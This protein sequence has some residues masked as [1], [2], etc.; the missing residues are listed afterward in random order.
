MIFMSVTGSS[1]STLGGSGRRNY[2]EQS[3]SVRFEYKVFFTSNLFLS[4]NNLLSNFFEKLSVA[5]S[6]QKV[7]F[8]IDEGVA[9]NR[10]QLLAQIN[11]YF[12]KYDSVQLI[13][14]ILVIPGGETAKN[15][16][17]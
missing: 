7:L 16:T 4:S 1:S 9:A 10:S 8:V 11:E 17:Q 15:D 2:I 13:K 5:G 14:D 6:V 12:E 3:F